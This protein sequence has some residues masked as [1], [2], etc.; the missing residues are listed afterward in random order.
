[1]KNEFVA[2]GE[3]RLLCGRQAKC[4]ET[5]RAKYAIEWACASFLKRTWLRW[6]IWRESLTP[7]QTV[8]NPSAGTLW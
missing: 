3:R 8:H 7:K 4:L 5:V 2:D 1:M 6:L